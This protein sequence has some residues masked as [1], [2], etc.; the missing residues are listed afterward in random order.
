MKRKKRKSSIPV[1]EMAP[2][3]PTGMSDDALL[4]FNPILKSAFDKYVDKNDPSTRDLTKQIVA[5][6]IKTG[7]EPEKIYATI[8]TGRMLTTMK[9][10]SEADIKEWGDAAEEYLRLAQQETES[11]FVKYEIT[12]R[13]R[14]QDE[15][16]IIEAA[17]KLYEER[18]AA[19]DSDENPIPSAEY[20]DDIQSAVMEFMEANPLFEVLEANKI[21]FCES[22]CGY[23]PEPRSVAAVQEE[24]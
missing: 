15:K 19:I 17:R 12:V 16:R 6:A 20:V 3:P 9:I 24:E 2:A 5:A 23:C 10:L 1:G 22:S 14:K 21:E 11:M 7:V 8:K 13:I 18:G 4:S